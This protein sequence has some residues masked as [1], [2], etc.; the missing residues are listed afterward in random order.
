MG[1]IFVELKNLTKSFGDL[2]AVNNFSLEINKGELISILGPSGWGKTTTLNL[3]AGFLQPDKGQII[4]DNKNRSF[5]RTVGEIARQIIKRRKES[6]MT[7][8]ELAKKWDHSECDFT[9]RKWA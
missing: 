4:I 7:Q 9:Y 6:G 8:K 2:K 5:F 3:I 1:C